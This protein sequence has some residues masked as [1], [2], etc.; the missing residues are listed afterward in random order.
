MRSREEEELER[1]GA[2]VKLLDRWR[3]SNV[4]QIWLQEQQH[5]NE[6]LVNDT[7]SLSS[8]Q[9]QE[10]WEEGTVQHQ[11]EPSKSKP[12]NHKW[13]NDTE[14]CAETAKDSRLRS[15]SCRR[16]SSKAT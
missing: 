9:Q 8:V 13:L 4:A 2:F 7:E 11:L 12:R 1:H 10:T 14:S 3:Q 16:S 5:V 15:G 6:Q